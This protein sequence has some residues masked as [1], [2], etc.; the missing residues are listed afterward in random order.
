MN[1]QLGMWD[2][3]SKQVLIVDVD[4]LVGQMVDDLTS[5][6]DEGDIMSLGDVEDGIAGAVGEPSHADV[7]AVIA[8]LHVID[9]ELG[10]E[11]NGVRGHK[12]SRMNLLCCHFQILLPEKS[13]DL[14]PE[15]HD[16]NEAQ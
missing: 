14:K 8:G 6:V 3:L 9:G 15:L 16:G 11:V 10:E 13:D 5:D 2:K 7:Q 4:V 12:Q 1:L